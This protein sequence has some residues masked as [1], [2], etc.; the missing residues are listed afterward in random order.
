MIRRILLLAG[1][2]T[3]GLGGGLALGGCATS[4]DN[5]GALLRYQDPYS[6]DY[7]EYQHGNG[8]DSS[9]CVGCPPNRINPDTTCAACGQIK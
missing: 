1:L 3:I 2:A 4:N 8:P 9:P 6:A 5:S 7:Y